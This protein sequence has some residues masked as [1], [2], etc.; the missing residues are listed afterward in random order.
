MLQV[1]HAQHT[2]REKYKIT[3]YAATPGK[4]EHSVLK[5]LFHFMLPGRTKSDQPGRLYVSTLKGLFMLEHNFAKFLLKFSSFS[6]LHTTHTAEIL[7]A[8]LQLLF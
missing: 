3:G 4:P 6:L 8:V 1:Q 2:V 5:R 7:L